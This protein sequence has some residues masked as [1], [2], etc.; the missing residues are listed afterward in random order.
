MGKICPAVS[1]I[2][3]AQN[4]DPLVPDM[5]GANQPGTKWQ[6]TSMMLH[7]YRF[8]QFH[9][10]SNGVNSFSGFR[11]IVHAKPGPHWHQTW[12]VF[13]PWASHMGKM[14]MISANFRTRQFH[15]TSMGKIGPAVFKDRSSTKSR[16]SQPPAARGQNSKHFGELSCGPT[17]SRYP[18]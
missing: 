17:F 18:H 13:G 11:D 5:T 3:N 15:K 6:M 2:C 9:R 8:R 7:N 4:L 14:I 1:E 10:T 12:Q 16:A